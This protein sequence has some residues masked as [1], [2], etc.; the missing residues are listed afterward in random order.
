MKV[1]LLRV[2]IDTGS[3]GI[4]GPLLNK[5]GN[6]EYI[7]I[8]DD[9]YDLDERTYSNTR[10]FITQKPLIDYFPK[11]VHSKNKDQPIHYDPEFETFT[12]GDS[13]TP[14]G[15]L[16]ELE[17]GDLLVFYCGL[18]GFGD[19]KTPQS[20][21][22]LFA[23][24]EVELAGYAT[25]LMSD[26]KEERFKAVFGKNYHVRH[27][28]VFQEQKETLVLVKGNPEGSRILDRAIK[29]SQKGTNKSG[30]PMNQISTE[31]QEYFGDFNGKIG[32]P[33]SSPRWVID[34]HV[35]IASKYIKNLT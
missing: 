32:F 17:K 14:K 22:Y 21:L 9:K 2:G 7:P 23:Y 19:Y 28:S 5:E 26:L 16:R 33:R 6:Y 20:S 11:G 15:R 8:P 13:T 24:F 27:D 35:D 18:N 30:Q 34:S 31:M 1:V 25:K 29:F 3:G 12:Y 4:H 10:G